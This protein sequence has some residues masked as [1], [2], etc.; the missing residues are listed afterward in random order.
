M[1]YY[2]I[3]SGYV[4]LLLSTEEVGP[5]CTYSMADTLQLIWLFY[6]S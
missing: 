5:S 2:T 1:L 3:L 4:S 6:F